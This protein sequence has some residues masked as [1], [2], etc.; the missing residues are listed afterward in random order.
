MLRRRLAEARDEYAARAREGR[1]GLDVLVGSAD[2]REGLG[3]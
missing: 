2:R 3:R 1:G